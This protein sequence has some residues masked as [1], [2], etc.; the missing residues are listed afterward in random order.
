MIS[1][2]FIFNAKGEV[3]ISRLFR[4]DI[5]RSVADLFRVHVIADSSNKSPIT[6]LGATS[7]LHVRHENLYVVAV[8]RGNA[9]AALVFEY[10]YRFVTLCRQYFGLLDDSTVKAN[11]VLIYELL[12]E[13]VDFGLPQSTDHQTL[14]LYITTE[15]IR[16]ERAVLEDAKQITLQATGA[17]SWRRPDIRYRKNEAFVDV[18][19][20]VNLLMST[21][22]T[23]LRSDVSGQILMRAYLSGMPEC[24]LGINDR[25]LLDRDAHPGGA[26][27][28]VAERQRRG[29]GSGGVEL[30]D[31]QFHQCVRLGRFDSDR[32]ISFVPPDGEFE[33]MRYRTTDSISLPFRVTPHFSQSSTTS[34]EYRV[35]VRSM[36]SPKVFAQNVVVKVP[37]PTNTANVKVVVGGGKAKYV[38]AENCVVWKIARFPGATDL[39]LT[40]SCELSHTTAGKSGKAWSRPPISMDFQVLMYT[41]SGLLV[42]FLKVFEKGSYESVKWV[43]YMTKAASYQIRF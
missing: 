13:V 31:V 42:R 5:K 41:A 38:G 17:I 37:T 1:A 3:L 8:T 28:A 11:F 26:E 10:L 29:Q 15:S 22:G 34:A 20:G 23:I 16:S 9:N 2:F 40:F 18:I 30:D 39:V 21:K 27:R 19:E 32:T 6:T 43:R 7:F 12:D 35:H 36:F 24:K 14:S 33:L 4:H 25:L